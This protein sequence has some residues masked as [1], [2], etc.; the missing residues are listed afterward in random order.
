MNSNMLDRL[1]N[2]LASYETCMDRLSYLQDENEQLRAKLHL[3]ENEMKGDVNGEE[4]NSDLNEKLGR[5]EEW[6]ETYAEVDDKVRKL[7]KENEHLQKCLENITHDRD[8]KAQAVELMT[9]RLEGFDFSAV[10]FQELVRF[11]NMISLML[12]WDRIVYRKQ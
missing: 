1:D 5:Y 2:V 9:M 12:I 3:F 7:A 10:V 6:T 8:L 11:F 4:Q